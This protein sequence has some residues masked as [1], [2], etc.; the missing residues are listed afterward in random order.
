MTDSPILFSAPM[1]RA[2]LAGTKT[3]TRRALKNGW[4]PMLNAPHDLVRTWFA[5]PEIPTLGIPN[6]WAE[7]GIYAVKHGTRGYNRFLGMAPYR[8]GDRLWVKETWNV[9]AFSQDGECAWPCSKIPTATEMAEMEELAVRGVPKVIYRES[10]RAREWFKDQ[11][12]RVSIHM[13]RWASRLTLLVTDVRVQRLQDISE[14]DAM[15]EGI[16][17]AQEGYALTRAGECWGPTAAKAYFHLW[18]SIN[19]PDAW[20]ENPWCCAVSFQVVRQNID[21]VGK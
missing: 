6:Q 4:Q 16:V 20:D 18:N 2:L 15:A 5:P 14:A 1:V 19:G 8:P 10:D 7:S 3:Q 11:P 21:E 9:F 12:W 13:P 17:A